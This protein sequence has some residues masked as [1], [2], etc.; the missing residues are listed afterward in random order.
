MD[1]ENCAL[2]GAG[3]RRIIGKSFTPHCLPPADFFTIS[4]TAQ[5]ALGAGGRWFKSIRPDY[6]SRTMGYE[7]SRRAIGVAGIL[8]RYTGRSSSSFRMKAPPTLGLIWK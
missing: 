7:P 6:I 3:Y 1:A 2:L 5:T 8:T 4:A